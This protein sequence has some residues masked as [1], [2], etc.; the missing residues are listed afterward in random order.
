MPRKSLRRQALDSMHYHVHHL[1]QMWYQREAFDEEDSIEDDRLLQSISKLT[2]MENTRYL[3]RNPKYRT[4]RTL[5]D[6]E[7]AISYTSKN[8]NDE[9]FLN[10]FRITR[11]SFFLLLEEMK[12]RKAFRIVSKRKQQRP[13]AYQLLV[14]LYRVGSEGKHGGSAD[15]AAYFGIGK[16]LVNN[17]IRRC[18][19]ALLE[20]KKETVYW[21]DK[22]RK[23]SNEKTIG[24]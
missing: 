23:I 19:K 1:R 6:M 14:F 24:S 8:F 3:F 16:G 5:F 9:E 21:P 7:D 17:Y 13:V 11:D 10:K 4:D 22:K 15:V 12:K 18:V 20:I 2:R